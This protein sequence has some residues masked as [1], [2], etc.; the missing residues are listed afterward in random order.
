[1]AEELRAAVPGEEL[2]GRTGAYV[3]AEAAQF[4]CFEHRRHF[5]PC[6]VPALQMQRRD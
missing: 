2:Q 4:F 3:R 1:M 5:T 6:R